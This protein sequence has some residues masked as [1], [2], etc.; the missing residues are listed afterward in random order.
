MESVGAQVRR[1]RQNRGL[2]QEDLAE[3]AGLNLKTLCQI[4]RDESASPR[5][6]TLHKIA[7]A[8]GVRTVELF[9]P[10][11][12]ASMK[13]RDAE[14]M[15]L[16]AIRQAL[17]PGPAASSEDGDPPSLDAL[18]QET[19]RIRRLH[20]EGSDSAV[21][22]TVPALIRDA[23]NAVRH[24]QGADRDRALT[25]LAM[26]YREA[27]NGLVQLHQE[28]LA[29]HAYT[30]AVDTAREAGDELLAADCVY[31]IAWAFL[32][33]CRLEDAVRNCVTVADEIEP[34]SMRQASG[35]HL[36]AWGNLLVRASAAAVRNNQPEMAQELLAAAGAAAELCAVKD[37]GP[38]PLMTPFGVSRVRTM[39]VEHAV[40]TFD[41][42]EALR[43]CRAVPQQMSGLPPKARNRHALDKAKA[44]FMRDRPGRAV[45]ILTQ[46][47]RT[48]PE[49]LRNQ[50]YAQDIVRD[51]VD[52][53]ARRLPRDLVDLA[54]FLGVAV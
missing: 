31:W 13:D 7:L 18:F 23:R 50:R 51:M 52:A 34:R 2:S 16:L 25:V 35:A 8:L 41:P 3:R 19:A 49:W 1:M 44:Y 17:M 38:G 15:T 4:E 46:V 37:D 26:A 10:D 9:R 20:D 36:A 32:R 48:H 21:I 45:E 33:Q 39:A 24:H 42:A 43:R 40:I 6:D 27:G 11:P 53:R 54:Q 47:R 22:Q 29:A 14:D 30:L 12:A 5:L 28:D